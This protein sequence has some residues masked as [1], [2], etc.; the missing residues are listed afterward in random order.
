[1]PL[2]LVSLLERRWRRRSR[3]AKKL[4]ELEKLSVAVAAH[5]VAVD[6]NF[7]RA[8]T[9]N[10]YGAITRDDRDVAALEFIASF[11]IKFNAINIQ[12][13]TA[14]IQ[15]I[16][17]KK[18]KESAGSGFDISTIPENGFDFE[19]WVADRLRLYGWDAYA[20]K[21][22]GDQGVDVVARREGKS[23]AI[24]CKLYS[25]P[26][27]NK[28][29]QEAFAGARFMRIDKAAVLSNASF[30]KSAQELALETDVLLL[31]PEDIPNLHKLFH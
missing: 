25:K 21:G 20:T 18:R 26:V 27:G 30:T 1:M 6:R 17:D 5:A 29:V 9:I 11:G 3:E 22:T 31:S 12:E 15:Y 19:A 28:A 14:H 2:F 13:A 23:I 10:D 8:V 7:R 16:I 4:L 24:Q